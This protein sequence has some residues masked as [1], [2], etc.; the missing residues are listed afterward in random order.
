MK[1]ITKKEKNEN[2]NKN[3]N[4]PQ[5][6]QQG[7]LL[8]GLRRDG[9]ACFL[10]VFHLLLLLPLLLLLFGMDFPSFVSVDSMEIYRCAELISEQT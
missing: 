4:G 7:M 5:G 3:A 8:D 6:Q 2:V 10:T 9:K 1:E